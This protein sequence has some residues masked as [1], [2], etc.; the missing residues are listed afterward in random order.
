MDF[1][2]AIA[3][4]SAWKSKLKAYLKNPDHSLKAADIEADNNCLLGSGSMAKARNGVPRRAIPGLKTEHARFHVAAAAIVRKAD[5]GQPVSEEVALG[6]QSN[7]TNAS[8][9]VVRAIMQI[10]QEAQ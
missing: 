6:S 3:A 4:H 2:H 5:A 8:A 1:D 10:K 7:F 9:A